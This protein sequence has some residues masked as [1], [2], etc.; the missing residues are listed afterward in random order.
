MGVIGSS[1]LIDSL[2]PRRPCAQGLAHLRQTLGAEHE[3]QQDEDEGDV[4]G[5]VESEHSVSD[6]FG[7]ASREWIRLA[8][9][10]GSGARQARR[11]E[12]PAN[13][14]T[15]SYFLISGPAALSTAALL[16]GLSN[17]PLGVIFAPVR[18]AI[19]AA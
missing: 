4:N 8:G 14:W 11:P 13:P 1:P 2:K 9:W 16:S 3:Q 5:V 7:V 15:A 18:S 6:R 17:A 19:D 10:F 12:P